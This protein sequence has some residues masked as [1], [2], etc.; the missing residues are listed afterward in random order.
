MLIGSRGPPGIA[1][2]ARRLSTASPATLVTIPFSHYSELARWALDATR[3]PYVE[4]AAMPGFHI[5]AVMRATGRWKPMEPPRAGSPWA[6]P[7]LVEPSGGI[8]IRD[9]HEIAKHVAA[10]TSLY[11]IEQRDCI[12]ADLL[13]C[14]DR[15]G[16]LTRRFAYFHLFE[17]LGSDGFA[18]LAAKNGAPG[19]QVSMLAHPATFARVRK[20]IST[21]LGVSKD[22]AIRAE[23]YI[24]AELDALT[25][26]LGGT[27]FLHGDH[28]TLADLSFAALLSPVLGVPCGAAGVWLPPAE[29]LGSE[30][31]HKAA[32]WRETTAG[33]YVAALLQR[34]NEIEVLR[35]G[36]RCS[37]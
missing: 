14:H 23:A 26:R 37:V 15:I 34:R 25:E 2:S 35:F 6:V 36:R 18:E 22:R 27:P 10:G 31:C 29:A 13:H 8:T 1:R 11:P 20:Y 7:M 12:E 16:P 3:T 4:A 24:S 19:W 32:A 30:Y 33:Q 17:Q 5:L 9:S 28:A 21:G